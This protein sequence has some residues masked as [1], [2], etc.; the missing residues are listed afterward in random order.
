MANVYIPHWN[1]TFDY[2]NVEEYGDPVEGVNLDM[3]DYN[4]VSKRNPVLVEDLTI[5]MS[6]FDPKEDFILLSGSPAI[7]CTATA[8]V[9]RM[10]PDA[11]IQFLRF[12]RNHKVYLPI[13]VEF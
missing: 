3:D 7:M 11:P 13:T 10:H 8:I 2:L 12:N 6:T 4:L 9:A 1:P 5:M